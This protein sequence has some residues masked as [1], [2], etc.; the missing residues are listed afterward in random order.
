M[1]NKSPKS[2]T[3]RQFL[4]QSARTATG[5]SLLGFGLAMHAKSGVADPL[6]LRPPGALPEEDFLSAC[7]RCGMCV[8]D[9]PYDILKLGRVFDPVTTGTPYFTARKASCE[10]CEDIPCVRNCP[11]NALDRQ[12]EDI[13]DARIGLAVLIDHETCLNY[14][15]LRCDVCYRVCP[16][17]DEAITLDMQRNTRTGFHAKF[18]PIVHSEYC[19]GCGKCEEACVLDQAAIKVMPITLAKGQ[20]GKHYRLGWEE[21]E[22]AGHSLVPEML[23]LPDRMPGSAQ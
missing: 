5:V 3:R 8:R 9:C 23:D 14:R 17:I 12:M 1:D 2:S 13:V 7:V 15:G 21:K 11:T 10:M 4:E 19:T 22:K 6:A 16:L 18:I 20:L